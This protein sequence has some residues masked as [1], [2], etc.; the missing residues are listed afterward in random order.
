MPEDLPQA[1]ADAARSFPELPRGTYL[2]GVVTIRS[3]D[4]GK[5]TYWSRVS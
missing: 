2:D 4:H 3:D 5:F 1:L